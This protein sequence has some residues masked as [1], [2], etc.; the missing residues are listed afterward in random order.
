MP[1]LKSNR[2]LVQ[3]LENVYIQV[4]KQTINVESSMRDDRRHARGERF[5][6]NQ[7][8]FPTVQ[9]KQFNSNYRFP[10]R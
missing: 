9:E 10:G 6:E 3:T 1:I 5:P 7:F 2:I 4:K 8:L